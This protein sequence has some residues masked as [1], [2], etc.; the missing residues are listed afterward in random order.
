M[1]P[2]R[3]GFYCLNFGGLNMCYDSNERLTTESDA[4]PKRRTFYIQET[5]NG[6]VIQE[7]VSAMGSI[8]VQWIA[9]NAQEVGN[10]LSSIMEKQV[11]GPT[12]SKKR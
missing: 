6:F 12:T 1:Q 3:D 2:D 4:K 8:G 5:E 7:H 10:V 11:V 9:K